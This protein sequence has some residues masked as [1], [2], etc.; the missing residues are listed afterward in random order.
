[1]ALYETSSI[2]RYVEAAFDGP[3]LIRSDPAGAA[4]AD[5]WISVVNA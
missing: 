3:P 4:L 5:R 2:C 1:M